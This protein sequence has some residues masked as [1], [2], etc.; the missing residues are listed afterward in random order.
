MGA[1]VGNRIYLTAMQHTLAVN[2]FLDKLSVEQG[3]SVHTRSAYKSDILGLLHDVADIALEDITTQHIKDHIASLEWLNVNSVRRM[4]S[5]L[6]HFFRF[7]VQ[8]KVIQ[9]SPMHTIE[10]PKQR[11]AL[12]KILTEEEVM[13]LLDY[14]GSVTAPWGLRCL[15]NSI[16]CIG[17]C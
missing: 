2:N 6:R 8:E 4:I 7:L 16:V 12:P 3:A 5:S 13:R 11:S 17:E 10:L 1:E 15:G 9:H 14:T